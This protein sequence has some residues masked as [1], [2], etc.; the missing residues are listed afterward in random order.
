VLLSSALIEAQQRLAVH[1][2]SP[3]HLPAAEAHAERV[4]RRFAEQQGWV[5]KVEWE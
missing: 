2:A 4:V 1:A 5:L 3:S